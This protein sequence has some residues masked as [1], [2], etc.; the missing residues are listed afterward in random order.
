MKIVLVI[1]AC[2]ISLLVLVGVINQLNPPPA[3]SNMSQSEK[4]ENACREEVG[5][6]GEAAINECKDRLVIEQ[7]AEQIVEAKQRENE[8][9][10]RVR[11]SLN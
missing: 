4:I 9:M 8:E 5:Y 3:Q 2:I 10:Q 11:D 1:F 7:L 6:K